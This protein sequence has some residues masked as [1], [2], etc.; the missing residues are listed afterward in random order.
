MYMKLLRGISFFLCLL[1]F[2]ASCSTTRVLADGEYRLAGNKIE[3]LNDKSFNTNELKPYLKQSAKGWSPSM[4]IYNWQNGKGRTWDKLVKKLGVEPTVYEAD[5]VESSISNII[6]H[7]EYL[8]YYDSKVESKVKVKRRKV[9]VEY[10]VKLGKRF[11]ISELKVILP[12]GELS[13][14][15]EEDP[16]VITL[17]EGDFLSEASLEELSATAS[18]KMRNK[19]FYGFNKTFFFFEA[20]T[21]ESG[22]SA[23]LE[24]RVE[25][26]T[27]NETASESRK[28]RI[29]TI[30]NVNIKHPESLKIR[31]R[32][33]TH[34]NTIKPGEIYS[35]RNV[36]NT[37]S[38]FSALKVFNSVN[39]EM[40]QVSEDVVDCNINLGQSKL[41]GFKLNAEASVNSSGLMG[42]SPQISYYHKNIFRGGEWLNLSFMGN[43]Q[44]KFNDDVRSNE[45]GVSGGLSFPRF[46]GL[47]D[48]LFE[49]TM[50]RT[51]INVAY[52]YQSRPEYTRNIIS[53]SYGYQ[54][55]FNNKL[56]YQAYPVRLNIVHLY[57][58]DPEFYT[59][60]EGDPFMRNAY[61]DHF[62]ISLGGQL[63]YTTNS[64][65]IPKS[66]YQYAS[67]EFDSSGNLLSAFKPLMKKDESGAGLVYDTPFSQYVRLQITLGKTWVFGRNDNHSIATRLLAGGGYAYG[68]S[69]ALPFEK[70]F[71]AGGANSLRGWQSRTVGPGLSAR[72]TSFVIPNQ[73]GDV[74][75]EANV[76]Y[77][78]D[79]FWKVE[80]AAFIDA[81]N[82][83][84]LK[85]TN[86]A[87][88]L[89]PSRLTGKNFLKGIALNWGI[90]LRL[91]LDFIL[92]RLDMGIRT[93]DPSRDEG[94]RWLKPR[95]W[96]DRNG[97][98]IHFGVGYPF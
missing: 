20:D 62:D 71:Y 79:M 31:E 47:P 18:A 96:F 11:P 36:N 58:M 13:R 88:P 89:K 34:I 35:E 73:T 8:G 53:T 52:N 29:F 6:N 64:D 5:L 24:M 17:K 68:N 48:R 12:E 70:H 74:K 45:F 23:K 55:N 3:V 95:E 63:Y 57:D 25:N 15:F 26:Y 33:L 84:T 56:Y 81:G 43:F 98:A 92:L 2:A 19:G 4:C 97:Y 87:D 94:A 76:E 32:V 75:F 72:D 60:L 28:H 66:S 93:H 78:F 9:N 90:G 37:Y 54:G 67:L 27:R 80:G 49:G 77:R 82:I 21:L 69:K 40:N 59:S 65:V 14:A 16:S 10:D 46:L 7:L 38:R 50:P 44:F 51:D 42:I 91:D 1:L 30:G 83:W 41:Q 86:S 39:V 85:E 61:Q 22:D